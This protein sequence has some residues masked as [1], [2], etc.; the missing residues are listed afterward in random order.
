MS[1]QTPWERLR[2][3]PRFWI[4]YALGVLSIVWLIDILLRMKYGT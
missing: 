4:G 3:W 2:P 1:E